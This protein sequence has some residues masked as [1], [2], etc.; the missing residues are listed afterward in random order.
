MQQRMDIAHREPV[1][2]SGLFLGFLAIA[3][4]WLVLG[5]VIG[6]VDDAAAAQATVEPLR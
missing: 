4:A 3:V 2:M 5:A 1:A 6:N